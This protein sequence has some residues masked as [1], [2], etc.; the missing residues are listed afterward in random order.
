[1]IFFTPARRAASEQVDR[2]LD[3]HALVK[4]RLLQAGPHTR[5]RGE[6]NHL[7]KFHTAE[8]ASSAARFRQV[9]AHEGERLAQSLKRLEPRCLTA[10]SVERIQ[11]VE[12]P[13]GVA[14]TEQP[15]ATCEPMNPLRP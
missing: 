8:Q 14:Q 1:V 15:L 2:A 13:T 4:R 6:V 9:T 7:I 10:G 3:V 5:P 11:V 12:S